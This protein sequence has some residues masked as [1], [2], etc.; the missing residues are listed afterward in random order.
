[1]NAAEGDTML[2]MLFDKGWPGAPHRVLRNSTV[3][4]WEAAG[5]PEAGFR[6]GEH[7]TVAVA[8]DGSAIER[9]SDT[10]PTRTTTGDVEALALYAGE[11]SGRIHDVRPA[12][13]IIE[14]LVCRVQ[15]IDVST[16]SPELSDAS[17]SL[18]GNGGCRYNGLTEVEHKK[19]KSN[20]R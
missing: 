14:D 1:L 8:S 6:P 15:Q 20:C 2:T 9:Y 12:G 17:V 5:C 18:G 13:Q 16:Q 10:I 4:L 11:S 19:R 7:D 3:R